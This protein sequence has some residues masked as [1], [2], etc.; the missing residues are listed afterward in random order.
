[1][2]LSRPVRTRTLV[3]LGFLMLSVAMIITA[4]LLDPNSRWG[5]LLLNFGTEVMGIVLTVSIVDYLF[6]KKEKKE[7]AKR[8]AWTA[9]LELDH[10]VWVWQGGNRQFSVEELLVLLKSVDADDSIP[11]FTQNL[12]IQLGSRAVNTLREKEEETRTAP[13]LTN[14]LMV[15][16]KLEA[17]RDDNRIMQPKEVSDLLL[18]TAS[19]LIYALGLH[20]GILPKTASHRDSSPEAQKRRLYGVHVEKEDGRRF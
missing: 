2:S 5:A 12:F 1:M 17:I 13:E 14:A 16:S 10:A 19:E 9:L 20:Q 6:Q 11:S 3:S 7:E 15:L 4:I 8:I 18:N